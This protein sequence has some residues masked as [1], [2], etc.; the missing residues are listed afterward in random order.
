M[1]LSNCLQFWQLNIC[2]ILWHL[3]TLRTLR[4]TDWT[5]SNYFNALFLAVLKQLWL[6]EAWMKLHLNC[7]WLN[8]AKRKNCLKLRNGH[9]RH[10][11]VLGQA[12]VYQTLHLT[13][14]LHETLY[15]KWLGIRVSGI[16][17]A[18]RC[19]IVREWPVN[20][21]HIQIIQLQVLQ[22]L[23]AGN[24]YISITMHVIPYLGCDEQIF[25]FYN[26]FCKRVSKNLSD[27]ILVA[28]AGSAVKGT[29]TYTDCASHCCG[30]S[31]C[32]CMVTSKCSHSY[33]WQLR[34]SIKCSLRNNCRIDH[35][36]LFILLNISHI[37]YIY[38]YSLVIS[39]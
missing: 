33:C 12:H 36:H 10:T 22:C 3:V 18:V 4:G 24:Q 37:F 6:L 1:C 13:P 35:C 20:I 16:H 8:S 2:N 7:G 23:S 11:N 21:V 29:V 30:N 19:M 34:A 27:H 5:E 15:C 26:T 17:I 14:G 38:Y 9:I 28:I 39:I 31:I 25:S 32:I